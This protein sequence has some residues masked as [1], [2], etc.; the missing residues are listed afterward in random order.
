MSITSAFGMYGFKLWAP[1][2]ALSST[3]LA[4]LAITLLGAALTSSITSALSYA[5]TVLWGSVL[6]TAH[7]SEYAGYA[8]VLA[9][10]RPG[11]A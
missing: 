8:G 7:A 2:L 11:E 10:K 9:K 4:G 3:L 5:S 6:A 1:K